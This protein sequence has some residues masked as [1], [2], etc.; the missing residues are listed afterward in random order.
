VVP[1]TTLVRSGA[2]RSGSSVWEPRAEESGRAAAW[3][4]RC[5]AADRASIRG[6]SLPVS[7][8][9]GENGVMVAPGEGDRSGGLGKEKRAASSSAGGTEGGL[10][11]Y[12]QVAGDA[13]PL[14]GE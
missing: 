7:P 9:R 1:Y 5:S 12:S 6:V 14:G 10:G 11:S 3:S 4:G 2:G 8:L 13:P